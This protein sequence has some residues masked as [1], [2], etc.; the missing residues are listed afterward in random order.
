MAGGCFVS[1]GSAGNL[2]AL[3]VARE[4][5]G[6]TAGGGLG[7]GG[8]HRPLVGRQLA[9]A[10]RAAVARR[11]DRRRRCLHRE[12]AFAPPCPPSPRS[13]CAVVASAG[14][15]NAGLI[16]DLAGLAEVGAEHK[17]WLHV[18]GAYGLA[19]LLVAVDP[20]SIRRDR[21]RRLASSST[22]TSG[23]SGR[24]TAARCSTA[25]L[26]SPRRSTPSTRPTWMR[27]T[28]T[29][30]GTPPTRLPPHAAHPRPAGVV[31]A[32]RPWRRRLPPGDRGRVGLARSTADRIRSVGPPVE[33]VMEPTLSVVLFRRAGW[34]EADWYSLVVR[35]PGRRRGLRDADPVEGR[36]PRPVGLPPPGDRRWPWSRRSSTACGEGRRRTGPAVRRQLT[37][38]PSST[39]LISHR[40]S[41]S[42]SPAA[43]APYRCGRSR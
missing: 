12:R 16:D 23:C 3:A 39:R 22:P 28:S 20:P 13:V 21:S 38:R 26:S 6:P 43:M 24:W 14:S 4:T 17:S 18:D 19:A 29:A 33:L 37:R 11:P 2:S 1:G 32:G 35:P 10:A 42:R 30:P 5:A 25:T 36:D 40:T 27:C 31:L 9:E 34:T 7:R 8:R 41:S 15:T